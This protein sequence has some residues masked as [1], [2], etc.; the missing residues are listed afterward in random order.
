M[1]CEN[2]SH[3]EYSVSRRLA[4][5]LAIVMLPSDICTSLPR[6]KG[7]SI[8]LITLMISLSVAHE[9]IV[10]QD[11]IHATVGQSIL[12]QTVYKISQTFYNWPSLQWTFGNKIIVYYSLQNGSIDPQ[13]TPLWTTGNTRIF[14]LYNHRVTFYPDNGS[15]LLTNLHLQDSGCYKLYLLSFE[16][17]INKT[18]CLHVDDP[19]L[20]SGRSVANDII[21]TQDS[22]NATV[23]HSIL[24]QTSYKISQNMYNWP[25]LQWTF[26]NRV[27]VY[28]S[29]QN[30]SIDPEGTPVLTRGKIQIFPLYEHRVTLYPDN[31]SLLLMNLHLQDSGCYNIYLLSFESIINKTICLHLDN[32]S[33][34]SDNKS[35]YYNDCKVISA[36]FCFFCGLIIFWVFLFRH[37]RSKA[38][39]SLSDKIYKK[40]FHILRLDLPTNDL[41][42]GTEVEF[43]GQKT[44]GYD[45]AA[46]TKPALTVLS[47]LQL[48]EH[49]Y[50]HKQYSL[51]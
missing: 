51:L 49:S 6:L 4:A 11:S 50:P 36:I 25:S 12:L 20:S 26:G 10:T 45:K 35:T 40:C 47:L 28:Y 32:P 41:E 33:L 15:L 34:L 44:V 9:I 46:A 23:G 3:L 1:K 5:V 16:S 29:L 17:I 39:P 19:S 21:V 31:G 14:P 13:G 24:L 18:I 27:I 8:L 37:C 7:A 30:G 2:T 43:I 22:V 48:K 42:A 38:C